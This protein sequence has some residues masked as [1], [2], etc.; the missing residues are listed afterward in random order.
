MALKSGTI[1]MFAVPLCERTEASEELF[2]IA[3]AVQDADDT[4]FIVQNAVMTLPTEVVSGVASAQ[5]RS[6][7]MVPV[8]VWGRQAGGLERW[9]VRAVGRS[10]GVAARG[11]RG[12]EV[13]DRAA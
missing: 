7:R 12:G 6:A 8:E 2:D 13:G 1:L 9:G 11:A 4:D 10:R 3:C 5:S